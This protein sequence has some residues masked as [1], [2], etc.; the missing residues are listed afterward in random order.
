M[1]SHGATSFPDLTFRF[2]RTD[3]HCGYFCGAETV[4]EEAKTCQT[5]RTTEYS[6]LHYSN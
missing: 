1:N 4:A 3:L 2:R 5:I 6:V